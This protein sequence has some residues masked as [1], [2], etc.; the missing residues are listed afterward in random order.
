LLL[1]LFGFLNG[2]IV[3]IDF[4][5]SSSLAMILYRLA[6]SS[7]LLYL[8]RFAGKEYSKTKREEEKYAFKSALSQ[9]YPSQIQNLVDKF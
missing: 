1:R 6:F 2:N 3:V 9:A 7:P 8:I 4:T 5:Q